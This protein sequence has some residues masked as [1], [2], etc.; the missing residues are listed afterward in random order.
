MESTI[1]LGTEPLCS[2]K[3]RP[4]NP[5]NCHGYGERGRITAGEIAAIGR[6]GLH[7]VEWV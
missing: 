5:L 4:V 1:L 7:K 3:V 2:L 6:A